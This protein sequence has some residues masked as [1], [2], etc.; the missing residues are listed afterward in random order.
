MRLRRRIGVLPP[1]LGSGWLFA[2][3]AGFGIITTDDIR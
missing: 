2:F 3:Q 1:D